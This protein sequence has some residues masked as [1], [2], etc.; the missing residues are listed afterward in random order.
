MFGAVAATLTTY[1]RAR[2]YPPYIAINF[3]LP[4]DFIVL[5][6]E[7]LVFSPLVVTVRKLRP[8]ECQNHMAGVR[9]EHA[10]IRGIHFVR[11]L[12]FKRGPT[13]TQQF[14]H[15]LNTNSCRQTQ[16]KYV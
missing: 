9:I 7:M 13:Q 8:L 6:M 12:K 11:G 14:E 1:S 10:H 4:I 16:H 3:S 2:S 5:W 15:R